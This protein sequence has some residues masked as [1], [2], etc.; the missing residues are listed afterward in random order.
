MQFVLLVGILTI[1]P[2]CAGG[3][4][5]EDTERTSM[6]VPYEANWESLKTIMAPKWYDDAK[7]GIM[8]H[9]GPLN[10]LDVI[11]SGRKFG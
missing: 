5:A 2:G 7:F 10:R 11:T 4:L 3:K 1:L 6:V 9:W 8:I